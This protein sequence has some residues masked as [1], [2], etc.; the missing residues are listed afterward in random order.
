[1][2]NETLLLRQINPGFIVD[3]RVTSQ[4]F[5][6]TPKDQAMLSVYDNDMIEPA[7]AWIHFTVQ[8]GCYSEGVLGISVTECNDL[9]L[10]ARSDPEPFPEHAVIDFT[11]LS[12]NQCESKSKKLKIKALARGWLYQ[13]DGSI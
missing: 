13:A 11:G 6:P 8:F 12:N 2:D 3:G 5:R 4:A 9:N 10:T 1:M 7:D